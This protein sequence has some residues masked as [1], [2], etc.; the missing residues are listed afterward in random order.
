MASLAP[1]ITAAAL[2]VLVAGT[3]A[4]A[5]PRVALHEQFDGRPE[6]WSGSADQGAQADWSADQGFAGSGGILLEV[7]ARRARARWK[8]GPISLEKG[9]WY[10]FAIRHRARVEHSDTGMFRLAFE[11]AAKT[12]ERVDELAG[13]VN[14]PRLDTRFPDIARWQ[15]KRFWFT[16]ALAA[17]IVTFDTLTRY[18]DQTMWFDDLGIV[19]ADALAKLVSP[20]DGAVVDADRPALVWRVPFDGKPA[21]SYTVVLARDEELSTDRR[22]LETAGRQLTFDASSGHGI[23]GVDLD[24]GWQTRGLTIR[25]P[26]AEGTWFWAAWPTAAAKDIPAVQL[27]SE[28]RSFH[29]RRS[30]PF[31]AADTTP[32]RVY[33]PLPLPD[34]TVPQ[35]HVWL[36]FRMRDEGGSGV[37]MQ[38]LSIL[39]N[40]KAHRAT[41]PSKRLIAA[42]LVRVA[43]T[44][45]ADTVDP[46]RWLALP[47]GVHRVD[48]KVADKAGNVASVT[49]QFG[50]GVPIAARTRIDERGRT[51]CNGLPFFPVALYLRGQRRPDV[52]EW[53]DNGANTLVNW[54][55]FA[56]SIGAKAL[57]GVMTEFRGNE[58]L[59][60]MREKLGQRTADTVD[61]NAVLGYWLNETH[62]E[63]TAAGFRILKELDPN[64]FSLYSEGWGFADYGHTSD[65]YFY[66]DYA[67]P[68]RPITSQLPRQEAALSARKPGQT[69]W[70]INQGYDF[71]ITYQR[72]GPGARRVF[73]RV[74]GFEQRP[75]GR[76]MRAMA[77]LAMIGGDMGMC[78]WAP[79]I[80]LD[81]DAYGALLAQM[82]EFAWVGP[83]Y[84]R[85]T[86]TER[87]RATW[88]GG[89]R[90][91][92]MDRHEKLHFTERQTEDARFLMV[93]NVDTA[94]LVATFTVPGLTRGDVVRV[95]FEDRA[96]RAIGDTFSDEI[97]GPGAHVYRIARTREVG[98]E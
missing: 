84:W 67:V 71:A 31:M 70:Y 30:T 60:Q 92:L 38:S 16:P 8:S 44:A 5:A 62:D 52:R 34:S 10:G 79:L 14:A 27:V 2:V 33:R 28:V 35:G 22:Q 56:G 41:K 11:G 50:V 19:A 48:V 93:V 55:T 18:G 83:V 87:T 29:V 89:P 82:R 65:G 54:S 51:F 47:A 57:V 24:R 98:P 58:D 75:T 66:N 59:G 12:P 81:D 45:D 96:L 73:S 25:R 76:E 78:W 23:S 72:P 36:S 40:G 26:L 3:V 90:R 97:A 15:V 64:H 7:K 68:N 91:F 86:P 95:M 9:R 69:T 49:W 74:P 13:V 1:W 80:D 39:I 85:E 37:D 20:Q 4:G 53:V 32:P 63:L 77:H 46:P 42:D 61:S 6:G 43:W 88:E 94:P 17:T 21:P